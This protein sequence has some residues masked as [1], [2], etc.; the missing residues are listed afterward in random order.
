MRGELLG[1]GCR[2]WVS[3]GAAVG[4]FACGVLYEEWIEEVWRKDGDEFN[5]GTERV[6]LFDR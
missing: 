6:V 2:V 1:A 4:R 5:C 3:G